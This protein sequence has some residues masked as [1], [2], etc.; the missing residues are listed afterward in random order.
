MSLCEN[1][2][3]QYYMSI[4][5]LFYLLSSHIVIRE[6]MSLQLN[7]AHQDNPR[8]SVFIRDPNHPATSLF[9]QNNR[10]TGRGENDQSQSRSPQNFT[11]LNY[12]AVNNDLQSESLSH[13]LAFFKTNNK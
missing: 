10:L 9:G 2:L 13:T 5:Y 4:M 11:L 7:T 12:S 8:A 3:D 6:M 1:T